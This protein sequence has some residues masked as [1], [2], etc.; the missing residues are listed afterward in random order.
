MTV[1]RNQIREAIAAAVKDRK[2]SK[3]TAKSIAEAAGV[4]PVRLSIYLAGKGDIGS[5]AAARLLRTLGLC[6]RSAR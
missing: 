2:A 6:V 4:H 3:E 5:D 1:A